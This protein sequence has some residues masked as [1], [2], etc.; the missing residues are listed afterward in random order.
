MAVG[1]VHEKDLKSLFCGEIFSP[2]LYLAQSAFEIIIIIS[3][4]TEVNLEFQGAATN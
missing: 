3:V 4:S 2:K 1:A